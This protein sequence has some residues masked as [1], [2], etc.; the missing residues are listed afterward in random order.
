MKKEKKK[1]NKRTVLLLILSLV[2]LTGLIVGLVCLIRGCDQE[3]VVEPEQTPDQTEPSS[4]APIVEDTSTDLGK[5]MKLVR[6]GEYTGAYVE[7]GTDEVVSGVLMIVVKN[8][9]EEAIQYAEISLPVA[10]GS[11]QFTVSTLMPGASVVLLEKSRMAYT[12]QEQPEL[13]VADTVA[14]F[15]ETPSLCQDRLQ[16]QTLDGAINVTNISGEDI[17]GD[18]LI[19]Y[20]NYTAGLYYGGITYRV[21]I[22]GGIG[23]GE[24]KQIMASHFSA[25]GSEIVFV[26]IG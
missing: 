9:G 2:L 10:D 12:G 8:T 5:G 22:E 24:I 26:T 19:Y 7:D 6:I 11:A 4:Q 16:L 13:A 3:P 17:T 25:S 21:R 20:K 18:V 1:V 14:V 23:A 15:H